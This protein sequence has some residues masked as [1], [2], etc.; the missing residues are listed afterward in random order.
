[1]PAVKTKRFGTVAMNDFE[2]KVSGGKVVG[3]KHLPSG[4]EFDG[5]EIRQIANCRGEMIIHLGRG[6]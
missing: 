5:Q 3:G 6:Q 4:R 2:L 1:M